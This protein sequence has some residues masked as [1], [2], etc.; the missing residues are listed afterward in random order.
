MREYIVEGTADGRRRTVRVFAYNA[1]QANRE[2]KA[3]LG[4]RSFSVVSN[5]LA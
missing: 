5:R 2:A 1:S 4:A 3:L